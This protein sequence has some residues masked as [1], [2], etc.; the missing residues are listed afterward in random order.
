M[1]LSDG[2]GRPI[3]YLRLSVTDRC[4]FRCVYCM[5][6]EMQFLPR[7]HILSIEEMTFVA[8]AFSEL[9]VSKIRLTGGEPLVRRNITQ[10]FDN[11]SYLRQ[12]DSNTL[13]EI[14]LT[15][16]GS[17]L[18]K[19]AHVL[20][21]AGVKRINIS[22]DSL[23]PDKFKSL[24]RK[25]NLQMVLDGINAAIDAGLQIKLNSVIL[26][27]RNQNEVIDLV[28]FA[29]EKKI[30]ISF[31]EEMPLGVIE[32]H[33]RDDEFISSDT[34]RSQI[35]NH[36]AMTPTDNH[37]INKNTAGPSRYWKLNQHTTHIGFISPHSDNFCA[38]CNRVR[39]TAEG[40][41][42]LCLGNENSL[43][44]RK[45]IRQHPNDIGILKQKIIAAMDNKPE[46][47]HFNLSDEPQ[48]VRFMNMTGG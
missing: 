39:V 46:K 12:Q 28:A 14:T 33:R 31:I 18:Q 1:K 26:K 43:D 17:Q 36:Y 42:L 37:S 10:L 32:E 9:G 35:E 47:H 15:T 34:L 23:D 44:L 22:L 38:S 45:I 29:V 19:Y 4:D 24:T 20:V 11:L 41:L 3:N 16:N 40:K 48:I 7:E 21:N 27:S 2:F 6:E 5:A 13:E 30:D 25:G 8:Q